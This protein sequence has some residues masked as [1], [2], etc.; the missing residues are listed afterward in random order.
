V[1]PNGAVYVT[2]VGSLLGSGSVIVPPVAVVEMPEDRSID[3][4]DAAGLARARASA[5]DAA[6]GGEDG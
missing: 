5:G 1:R 6:Q 3:V 4:D 2:A